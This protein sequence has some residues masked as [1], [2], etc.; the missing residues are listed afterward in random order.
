MCTTQ[1]F[2]SM[3]DRLFPN[4]GVGRVRPYA[5]ELVDVTGPVEAQYTHNKRVAQGCMQLALFLTGA[6]EATMHVFWKPGLLHAA[7]AVVAA[8]RR[9]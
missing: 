4:S 2:S 7:G 5:V 8:Q 1:R 6:P 3:Y 9:W